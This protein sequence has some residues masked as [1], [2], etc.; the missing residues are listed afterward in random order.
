MRYQTARP[1]G[2]TMQPKSRNMRITGAAFLSLLNSQAGSA[3]DTAIGSSS[4]HS[5]SMGRSG[6]VRRETKPAW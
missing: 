6:A 3:T 4:G 2:V 1:T 5:G